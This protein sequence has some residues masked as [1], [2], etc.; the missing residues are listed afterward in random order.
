M[1]YK[2]A[3]IS[4]YDYKTLEEEEFINDAIIDFYLQWLHHEKLE[5]SRMEDIHIFNSHF[6]SK[7]KSI[8]VKSS[9]STKSKS[10]RA[11]EWVK[12][13]TKKVD[14]F[15]KQMVVVP[16]CEESHWYVIIICNPGSISK[17]SIEMEISGKPYFLVLDSLGETHSDAVALL[18]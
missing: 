4:V 12:N 16:I 2:N 10:A 3:C 7:L 13:W 8:P 15:S 6:Y 5:K 18:R 1:T 17:N 9:D 11:Y 14:L